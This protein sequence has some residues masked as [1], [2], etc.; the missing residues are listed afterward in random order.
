MSTEFGKIRSARFDS[1]IEIY[2]SM[3]NG[4]TLFSTSEAADLGIKVILDENNIDEFLGS[5]SAALH[6]ADIFS[7]YLNPEGRKGLNGKDSDNSTHN[8]RT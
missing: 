7:N 6:H 5:L 3:R 1:K 2:T 4:V 8:P